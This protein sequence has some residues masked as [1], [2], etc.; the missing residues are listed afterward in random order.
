MT[1]AW[2]FA[3]A[4]AA[5][6][7]NTANAWKPLAR[8]GGASVPSFFAGWLT[9]ELP[10][11]AIAWQAVATGVFSARHGLASTP[12]RIALAL[13]AGSWLALGAQ[14]RRSTRT[15][16]DFEAVF[17]ANP[18]TASPPEPTAAA[19]P[20]QI[21]NPFANGRRRY[22]QDQNVSYGDFGRRNFLDVWHPAGLAPDAK[23][24]VLLQIHGGAWMIGN[25]EQQGAPLMTE[26][27]D[28][29]WVCVA[30]NYRL[31]PRATWPDHIV[32]VKRALAWIR[33]NIATYG[34]DPDFVA[35]TGG[36]AGGHLSS[37]AA[38]S[39][40]DPTLQPGFEGA[41]TTVQAAVPF[42]GVYDFRNGDGTGRDDMKDVLERVVLKVAEADGAHIWDQAS[43]TNWVHEEAP[44][45]L[46]IH[47]TND[48]LVPVEQARAF[49]A[50]L[51]A[52]STQ[53][54]VF[55]ELPGAQHAFDV[56]GSVR[57]QHAVRAVGRF[58]RQAHDDH[59][60]RLSRRQ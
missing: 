11:H 37:L 13:N 30:I 56:F 27:C 15:D 2:K 17:A 36:S 32:D 46:V 31:S 3:A 44:P 52:R 4:A 19:T 50:K 59:L 24:P 9:S 16:E 6:A 10:L 60:E 42:Y 21:A 8:D 54:V 53:P 57:T 25:K 39:P 49:V 7:I 51:R 18:G 14:H 47:G 45:F 55:V 34:G 5:G 23:A 33:A 40:N 12:A 41:D 28:R 29:G 26:M 35:I 22:L 43:T 1:P 20:A 38:L 48:S 58:L